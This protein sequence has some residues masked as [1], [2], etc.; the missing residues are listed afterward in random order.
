[1]L[2]RRVAFLVEIGEPIQ[3]R[4]AV[5]VILGHDV[6]LHLA[7]VPR[8]SDLLAGRNVLRGKEQHLIAQERL[9]DRAEE[10]VRNAVSEP[11][12]VYP[13]AE[14]RCQRTSVEPR[15]LGRGGVHDI[16]WR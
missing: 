14:F 1:M 3:L 15:D 5:G 8:E 6:D 16:S 9:I 11:H 4:M 12:A 10:L 2:A 13:G 7:E